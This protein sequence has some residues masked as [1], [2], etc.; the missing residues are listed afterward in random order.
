MEKMTYGILDIRGHCP[1]YY[2]L[3]KATSFLY[4]L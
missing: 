2:N 4:K 1:I 3:L